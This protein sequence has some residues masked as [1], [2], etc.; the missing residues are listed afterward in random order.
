M[1]EIWNGPGQTKYRPLK[2][3]YTED[4]DVCVLVYDI[5][6]KETFDEI[7]NYWFKEIKALTKKDIS[8]KY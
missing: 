3:F 6:R 2:K 8:K 1:F 4:T 7:K 5:T